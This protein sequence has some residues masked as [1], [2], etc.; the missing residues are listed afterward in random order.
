M[1][2]IA[3]QF[4]S[5]DINLHPV[6]SN[7]VVFIQR[8]INEENSLHQKVYSGHTVAVKPSFWVIKKSN[9]P[10]INN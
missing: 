3:E 6:S 7:V 2:A 10:D 4:I 5:G 1:P 9:Y 8:E